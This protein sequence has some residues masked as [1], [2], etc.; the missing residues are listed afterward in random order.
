MSNLF[1]ETY[2]KINIIKN[3]K[4]IKTA[5]SMKNMFLV[6]ALIG[7]FSFKN[8]T[9]EET[10]KETPKETSVEIIQKKNVLV[11]FDGLLI[12][13]VFK[14]SKFFKYF[15]TYTKPNSQL[16]Q[17]NVDKLRISNDVGI[18]ESV[19][20]ITYNGRI[21]DLSFSMGK[22][23]NVNEIQSKISQIANWYFKEPHQEKDY[24]MTPDK[25]VKITEEM[26]TTP[27]KSYYHYE[28]HD[29]KLKKEMQLNASRKE[30]EDYFKDVPN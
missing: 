20:V 9:P 10:P 12:G 30:K 13:S 15:T 23:T 29:E 21:K 5:K 16:K 18:V 6:L 3:L 19:I 24:Y 4:I 26:Y 2:S 25:R 28:F 8:N 27:W 7:L 22:Y 14:D 17:Y 11:G 1:R